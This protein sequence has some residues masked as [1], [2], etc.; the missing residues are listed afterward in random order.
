MLQKAILQSVVA[1]KSAAHHPVPLSKLIIP[2]GKFLFHAL[3][4]CSAAR[5]PVAFPGFVV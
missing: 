1:T 3:Y 5:S 2:T 4:C